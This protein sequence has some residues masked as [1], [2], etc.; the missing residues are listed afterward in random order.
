MFLAQVLPIPNENT[1][2]IQL[3]N[4]KIMHET[5]CNDFKTGGIKNVDMS[6]KISCLQCFWVKNL[7]N[8]NSEDWKLIPNVFYQ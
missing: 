2:T 7:C 8:Q 4:I 5:A 3:K 1:T 6:S